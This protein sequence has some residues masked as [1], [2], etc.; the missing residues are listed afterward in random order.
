MCG[1]TADAHRARESFAHFQDLMGDS[2]GSGT[3]SLFMGKI[4]L[5]GQC[6]KENELPD[7]GE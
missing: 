5:A 6:L 4:F 3:S 2:F 1:R 7:A